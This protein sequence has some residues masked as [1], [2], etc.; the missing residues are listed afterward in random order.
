MIIDVI[1]RE[2][3]ASFSEKGGCSYRIVNK[4]TVPLESSIKEAKEMMSV[5][6]DEI[7]VLAQFQ[8]MLKSMAEGVQR[9]GIARQLGDYLT[10]YAQPYGEIDLDEG[11]DSSK[12]GFYLKARLLNEME[13]DISSWTLRDG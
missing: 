4:I 3:P 9:D 1:K 7:V 10:V 12:A 5:V 8:G 2:I 6:G 13:I 11:W